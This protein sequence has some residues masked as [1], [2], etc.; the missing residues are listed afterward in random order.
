[1]PEEIQ[2]FVEGHFLRVVNDPD[3]LRVPGVSLAHL[4]VARVRPM[5]SG[6]SA[7]NGRHAGDELVSGLSAPEAPA[8]QDEAVSFRGNRSSHKNK[9]GSP[10]AADSGQ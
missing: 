6:I 7:D 4:A 2:Q 1:L 8:T 3:H 5:P 9:G 10:P